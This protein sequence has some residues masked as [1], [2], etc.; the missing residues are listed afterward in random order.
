MIC[1]DCGKEF[2]VSPLCPRCAQEENKWREPL[3]IDEAILVD[4]LTGRPLPKDERTLINEERRNACPYDAGGFCVKTTNHLNPH[5]RPREWT[6]FYRD[7]AIQYRRAFHMLAVLFC[8]IFPYAVFYFSTN[9]C[10]DFD[11]SRFFVGILISALSLVFLWVIICGTLPSLAGSKTLGPFITKY[12]KL[13]V[14]AVIIIVSFIAAHFII[15]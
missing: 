15:S 1:R 2:D 9:T 8:V 3:Y 10:S 14:P 4:E 5:F 6:K 7:T 11:L 12:S 13:I